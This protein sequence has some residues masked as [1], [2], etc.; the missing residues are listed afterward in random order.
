MMRGCAG[1]ALAWTGVSA[2]RAIPLHRPGL[3]IS[4]YFPVRGSEPRHPPWAGF[5]QLGHKRAFRRQR[6]T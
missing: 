5:G 2:P 3:V 4:P 6:R 1:G